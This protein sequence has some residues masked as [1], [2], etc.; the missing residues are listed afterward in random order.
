MVLVDCYVDYAAGLYGFRKK[1]GGEL[2][3]DNELARSPKEVSI[4]SDKVSGERV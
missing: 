4:A 2:N 1:D 3:L